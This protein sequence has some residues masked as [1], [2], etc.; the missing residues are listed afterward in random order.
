MT[1]LDPIETFCIGESDSKRSLRR[2]IHVC[3]ASAAAR[4]TEATCGDA[5]SI[6]WQAAQLAGA[7]TFRPASEAQL[8]DAIKALRYLYQA[9]DLIERLEPADGE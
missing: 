7:W 1:K 2:R 6:F 8:E 4:A 3:N 9:A 5:R